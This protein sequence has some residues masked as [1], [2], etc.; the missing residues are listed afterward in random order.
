MRTINYAVSICSH[1]GHYQ[2]QKGWGGYCK[3]L[4]VAVGKWKACPLA[5]SPFAT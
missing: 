4:G 3:Q 5:I 2:L 1:C